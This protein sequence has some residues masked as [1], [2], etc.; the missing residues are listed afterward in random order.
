MRMTPVVASSVDRRVVIRYP[1]RTK[2]SVTASL[3]GTSIA[4]TCV[5]TTANEANARNPDSEGICLGSELNPKYRAQRLRLKSCQRIA[6][7]GGITVQLLAA[8]ARFATVC[9]PFPPGTVA[10]RND[11]TTMQP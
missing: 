3:P 7:G 10:R 6:I 4:V 2:K 9:R 8:E 1:L 5:K 11:T